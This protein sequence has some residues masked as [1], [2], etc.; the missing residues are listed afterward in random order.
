MHPIERLR[1]VAR[2]ADVPIVMVVRESAGALT[3]FADDPMA[4]L[5]ACRRLLDRRPG[6][7][8]LV[9][10]AAR[11]LT[12]PDPRS[13]AWDAVEQLDRDP[14][15]RELEHALP[16][17]CRVLVLGSPAGIGRALRRRSDVTVMLVEGAG[18]GAA[19]ADAL[20]DAGC[21][22]FD[23]PG[24][25]IGVAATEADIVLLDAEAIG[26][27]TSVVSAG[28]RAAAAVAV[29]A[30]RPVWLMAGVGLHLPAR[31]WEAMLGRLERAEPWLSDTELLPR[32]PEGEGATPVLGL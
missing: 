25:G 27:D 24:S 9:W 2:A 1:Y 26:P 18:A 30:G 5:T 7:A 12:G 32:R 8:P 29:D 15:S 17:G 19:F 11:M 31:M 6:S 13:E 10:L 22:V 3:A 16:E 20:V 14:T 21:E 23:V 28:S 4:L